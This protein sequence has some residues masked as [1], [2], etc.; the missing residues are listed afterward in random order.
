VT[1]KSS[2]LLHLDPLAIAL[3]RK[4]IR[5]E[6][7]S[8]TI[9][10]PKMG[11]QPNMSS[12]LILSSQLS[13]QPP[14][15]PVSNQP[16]VGSQPATSSQPNVGSQKLPAPLNLLAS[17]PD[18]KGEARIPHRYSDYLCRMLKPDEQ[19]VYWQLYRLS[20]GWG[21]DA[22]FIS[23]PKLS[24]RSNVPLS[25]MKRAVA[26]L[27]SKGL[28][29]KTGQTNGYG[30][31]QGVEYRVPRL[32][33]QPTKSSQPNTSSQPNVAPNK[34]KAIKENTQTAARASAPAEQEV[35]SRVG[36]GS[37]YTLEEC[38]RF[39]ESLRAEGIQNPGGYA[40]AIHRSGEA[41]DRVEAFL[42]RQEGAREEKP[43]LSAEQV[44]EQANIAA[45][46]LQHGSSI[47]EV[48]QFLAGNFRPA[49]WH[50]IRS[51]ALTQA[52]LAGT[53]AK[54]KGLKG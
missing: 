35:G 53:P 5:E 49:Q 22:C 17:V 43:A 7:A 45:S 13:E 19:A 27:V 26:G 37:R 44:Q 28:V 9:S 33:W 1:S 39:A 36:V 51:V 15:G 25:S 41:D 48:E 40:T 50:M 46:M 8:E 16:N 18:I 2:K 52:K 24:E 10:E 23:N 20:W 21:K 29:E 54:P 14:A 4:R 31:D 47:E 30:K 38:R 34:I 11:S 6:E 42:A 32:D 12:Q 3:E